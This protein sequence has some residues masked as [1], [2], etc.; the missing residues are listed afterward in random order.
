MSPVKLHTHSSPICINGS[1]WAPQMMSYCDVVT[2]ALI[3]GSGWPRF[4][5]VLCHA[6]HWGTIGCL[7]S[8][9]PTSQG[10]CA[11]KIGQSEQYMPPWTPARKGRI[12]CTREDES[13]VFVLDRSVPRTQPSMSS[14]IVIFTVGRNTSASSR[15]SCLYGGLSLFN[16]TGAFSDFSGRRWCINAKEKK[17]KE[18]L[19]DVFTLVCCIW[20]SE[21]AC[22]QECCCY[23]NWPEVVPELSLP[24]LCLSSAV[25]QMAL[26]LCA[27]YILGL[28]P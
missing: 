1:L 7:L 10:C 26:L 21:S 9:T 18:G 11:K 2:G 15:Y 28:D 20:S 8:I 25:A 19:P 27:S 14:Y 17:S 3:L 12:K 16:C 24:H 23:C 4:K 22:F 6:A 5:C 13:G